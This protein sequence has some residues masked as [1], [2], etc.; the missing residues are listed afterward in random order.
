MSVSD[1]FMAE[2]GVDSEYYLTNRTALSNIKTAGFSNVIILV[3][4]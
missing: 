2:L 3:I 4:S 1:I